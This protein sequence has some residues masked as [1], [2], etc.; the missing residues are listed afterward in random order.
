MTGSCLWPKGRALLSLLG[1]WGSDHFLPIF[2]LVANVMTVQFWSGQLKYD[3]GWSKALYSMNSGKLLIENLASDG[4]LARG[5]SLSIK[6]IFTH[7]KSSA[8]TPES[9]KTNS[10]HRRSNG[11]WK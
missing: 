11:H 3:M 9:S 10:D 2:A 4:Q 7:T 1:N 6:H 8:Q 5:H